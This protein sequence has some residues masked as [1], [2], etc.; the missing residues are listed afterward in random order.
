MHLTKYLLSLLTHSTDWPNSKLNLG[1]STKSRINR[2]VRYYRGIYLINQ[3][4]NAAFGTLFIPF[5][6]LVLLL[7]FIVSFFAIVR[8]REKL[9]GISSVMIPATFT[10]T[11]LVVVPFSIVM[12]RMYQSSKNFK[13]VLAPKIREFTRREI[14]D[15]L[16]YKVQSCCLIRCKV[17][18]MYYM[19]AQAKLTML[20]RVVNGLVFLLVN[21]K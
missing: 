12:S 13:L 20:D 1:E 7:G 15:Y 8:L 18:N 9:D 3:E 2:C 19:E 17:G 14:R 6:K 16:Q 5:V 10:A 4:V 11:V 21:S